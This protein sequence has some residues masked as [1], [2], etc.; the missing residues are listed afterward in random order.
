VGISDGSGSQQYSIE[1]SSGIVGGDEVTPGSRLSRSVVAIYGKN[2]GLCSGTII[3]G[4]S[5]LTAA[6][7]IPTDPGI[8]LNVLFSSNIKN[9]SP[10]LVRP[11]VRSFVNPRW[12]TSK[13][14]KDTGDIAIVKFSG[15]LPSGFVPVNFLPDSS[16]V[17]RGSLVILSGF[18][19]S[20][21]VHESGAGVLRDTMSM[22][23]NAAFS[24]SEVELSQRNGRGTCEGDSGGPAFMTYQGVLYLWGV[25][26]RGDK[27]CLKT[28]IYTNALVYQRW[29]R[30]ILISL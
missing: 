20:D 11:V 13:T 6:H 25:V 29:V 16:M 8:Q 14:G 21:G 10:A 26:S 24:S 9:V 15:G 22:I 23:T 1:I 5:I 17:A 4:N 12:G 18:G 28:G 30:E 3:S 7:C 2:F 19:V 27:D